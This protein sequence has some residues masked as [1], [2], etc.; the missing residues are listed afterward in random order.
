[1]IINNIYPIVVQLRDLDFD[2]NDSAVF[3]GYNETARIGMKYNVD[4]SWPD[5]TAI[6]TVQVE[7]RVMTD[8]AGDLEKLTVRGH[9]F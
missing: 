2:N 1:M 7:H 6:V 8:Q 3:H 4:Y 5:G 9:E